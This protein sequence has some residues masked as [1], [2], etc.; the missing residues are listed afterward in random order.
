MSSPTLLS[1]ALFS[2]WDNKAKFHSTPWFSPNDDTAIREFV[3]VVNDGSSAINASPDDYT[4][5]RIGTFD[6]DTGLITAEDKKLLSLGTDVR[7]P[8]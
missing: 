7:Q 4:L 2:I 6:S 5:F 3:R 8:V 1:M